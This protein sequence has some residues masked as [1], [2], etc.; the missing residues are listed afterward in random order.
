MKRTTVTSALATI[1]LSANLASAASICGDVND[2]G[3][4]TAGDA[5]VVLKAAVGQAVE[6]TCP[7]TER[8]AE[9]VVGSEA[10]VPADMAGWYREAF[11]CS[12]VE[13]GDWFGGTNYT[14]CFRKEDGWLIWNTGCGWSVGRLEPDGPIPEVLEFKRRAITYAGVCST[15]PLEQFDTGALNGQTLLNT[16]GEPLDGVVV[17]LR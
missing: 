15:M 3:Q 12:Q 6:L 13:G 7:V 11:D 5:L 14:H 8:G 10:T 9:I 4:L 2:N 17:K 16:F 1:V